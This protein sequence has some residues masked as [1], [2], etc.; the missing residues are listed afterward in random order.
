MTRTKL[1]DET[2]DELVRSKSRSP[3][4]PAPTGK[5]WAVAAAPA[6]T[7]NA[8]TLSQIDNLLQD[9]ESQ[10]I[11]DDESVEE[12]PQNHRAPPQ[13]SA[14]STSGG[15]TTATNENGC[16]RS[17]RLSSSSP[18]KRTSDSISKTSLTLSPKSPPKKT[19]RRSP[20]AKDSL[21]SQVEIL[22]SHN[23]NAGDLT[24]KPA[25]P[26]AVCNDIF[27]FKRLVSLTYVLP[28]M[29]TPE[30]PLCQ[31]PFFLSLQHLATEAASRQQMR[32]KV[33]AKL[34]GYSIASS[35]TLGT[36]FV[37]CAKCH[38]INFTPFHMAN[39]HNPGMV[40]QF[41][42]NDLNH[43]RFPASHL[44]LTT[45]TQLTDLESQPDLAELEEEEEEEED[46]AKNAVNFSSNW[47]QT[48]H[49]SD[50]NQIQFTQAARNSTNSETLAYGYDCPRCM[51]EAAAAA[52]DE[53]VPPGEYL[54][55]VYRFWFVLRDLSS[56][57]DPCLLEGALA[58]RFLGNIEPIKFYTNADKAHQVF[59]TIHRNFNKKYLFTIDTFNMKEVNKAAVSF[60][61]NV[62]LNSR[63]SCEYLVNNKAKNVDVMYKIIE[64]EELTSI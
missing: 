8:I 36:V 24:A 61:Q 37:L 16:R 9:R 55:Y 21:D 45:S 41:I 2:F 5:Q 15:A 50:S 44:H 60:A 28:H 29:S 31:I 62:G 1:H 49:P 38:Y 19:A 35:S 11:T 51:L 17:L 53:N 23:H 18:T 3:V 14:P 54:Q 43:K 59:K 48:A 25:D 13:P 40:R 27:K 63:K 4:K 34:F 39:I 46:E 10:Y 26:L 12:N 7:S 58:A 42:L 22:K 30:L 52:Q 32:C 33:A 47:L 6:T 20:A 57:L 64:M 56:R